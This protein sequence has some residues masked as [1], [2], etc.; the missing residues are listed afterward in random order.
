M[1]SAD[2]N[3]VHYWYEMDLLGFWSLIE[4]VV[5][6]EIVMNEDYCHK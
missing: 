4:S 6:G 3:M 2:M 5:V 1:A